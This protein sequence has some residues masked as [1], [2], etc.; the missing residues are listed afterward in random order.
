[1][2]NSSTKGIIA[3]TV[4]ILLILLLP[5]AVTQENNT[6]MNNTTLKNITVLNKT[7]NISG[8]E[9]KRPMIL[10]ENSSVLHLGK[11][12][13]GGAIGM[14]SVSN[15]NTAY[16]T[17]FLSIHESIKPERIL[18]SPVKPVRDLEKIFFVCNIV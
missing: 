14:N 17:K 1:M 11:G 8:I 9:T 12:L 10:P 13:N 5:A 6:V 16:P 4:A 2:R 7:N 3:L 15:G 18:G